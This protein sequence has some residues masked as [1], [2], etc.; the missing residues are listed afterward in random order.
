MSQFIISVRTFNPPTTLP[1]ENPNPLS[2]PRLRKY[3]MYGHI[4]NTFIGI[5]IIL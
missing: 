4:F 2:K 3:L 5:I 1:T